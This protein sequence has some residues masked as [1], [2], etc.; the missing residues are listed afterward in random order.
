M[1]DSPISDSQALDGGTVVEAP[2]S[3]RLAK[4]NGENAR[5]RSEIRQALTRAQ[6]AEADAKRVRAST[7][8]AVGDLL[9]KA[10]RQPRRLVLL[11]RDMVRL[12]RL[13]RHRRRE[14]EQP[15]VPV[16]AM[17][18][19][20]SDLSDEVAAR[21]LLPRLG[22]RSTAPLSIAGALDPLTAAAWSPWAAVTPVLPH[23]AGTLI[24]EVDPDIAVIDTATALPLGS[25]S[26][27][28]NPS[29]AD[30]ALAAH[31]L[32]SAA[33]GN[34]RPVM[35]L[36]GPGDNPG[37]DAIAARCDY[38]VDIP[39]RPPGRIVNPSWN[40]GVD[41][42]LVQRVRPDMLNPVSSDHASA[43]Y[44]RSGVHLTA[45]PGRADR[46]IET[47]WRE[48]L[49][50]R[51]IHRVDCDPSAPVVTT[52]EQMLRQCSVVAVHARVS[53]HMIGAPAPA[54]AALLTGCRLVAPDDPDLRQVLGLRTDQDPHTLGWFTY[55]AGDGDAARAALE[56]ALTAA[57][58]DVHRRWQVW[59]ALSER[60]SAVSAWADVVDELGL[61]C[62]PSAARDAA[63]LVVSADAPVDDQ[64]PAL[65]AA[66]SRQ[67]CP[68]REIVCARDHADFW[69][70]F[71]SDLPGSDIV[72]HSISTT[73]DA[74]VIRS[75]AAQAITSPLLIDVTPATLVDLAGEAL[76]DVILAHELA[77]GASVE[78][79]VGSATASVRVISRTEALQPTS[80]PVI[81]IDHPGWGS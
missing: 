78:L 47:A 69:Q 42:G 13:R 70:H 40:P 51:G 39:G 77:D 81:T 59:R 44:E 27:L 72:V 56:S 75:R 28:G 3:Q 64:R 50:E 23:E 1:T 80:T 20:R 41:L 33:R 61:G 26:H 48:L 17:R 37:F 5:L 53:D 24:A 43:P 76:Q 16:S 49:H 10:A 66:L 74:D 31:A 18:A 30:R 55:P 15:E 60:A 62:R 4:L 22:Q 19:R 36:R 6:R 52:F 65:I 14:P 25:W 57:P 71:I 45:M 46:S 12:Y 38:V 79:G 21:L 58:L 8:F 32:I 2:E 73:G 63:L 67:T 9:V 29:A 7:K 35:L 34:G 54:L 11:P 68:P